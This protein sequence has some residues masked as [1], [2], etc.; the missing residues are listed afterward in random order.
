MLPPVQRPHGV[1]WRGKT[2]KFIWKLRGD[3]ILGKNKWNRWPSVY[4]YEERMRAVKL[5]TQ[6]DKSFVAVRQELGYPS[7][8][9]HASLNNMYHPV[10]SEHNGAVSMSKEKTEEQNQGRQNYICRP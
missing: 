3:E 9:P 1:K 10:Q 4:S 6:Y 5:Y 8:R 2:R 7:H